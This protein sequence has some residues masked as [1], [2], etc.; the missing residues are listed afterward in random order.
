[1]PD[2]YRIHSDAFRTIERLRRVDA[3]TLS[4][5]FTVEDPKIFTASWTED[6]QMKLH[7]EWEEVG[8][9]EFVCQENNRCPGGEC[10]GP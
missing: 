9:Y 1:V 8:L 2:E 10:G 4:Y 3:D 7:P 6:L 5:A